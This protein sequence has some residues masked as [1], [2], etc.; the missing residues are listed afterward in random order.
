MERDWKRRSRE[1]AGIDDALSLA[2]RPVEPLLTPSATTY[3]RLQVRVNPGV[4]AGDRLH[5]A[6]AREAATEQVEESAF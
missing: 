4:A 2:H 5:V 6:L 3:Q 1:S